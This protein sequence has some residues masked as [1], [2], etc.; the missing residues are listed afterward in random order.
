[1][2]FVGRT[3]ALRMAD[4]STEN[5]VKVWIDGEPQPKFRLDAPGGLYSLAEGLDSGEHTVEVVRLTECFLG[6]IQFQGFELDPS[7]EA[8]PWPE[9]ADRRI[10]FIGDSITCGY[11]V[12]ASDPNARFEAST[13]NFCDAY[14]GLTARQLKA[15][16]LVVARSGIG[17]VRNYNGPYE[18]SE[19]TMPKIYPE[20]FYQVEG[21]P[22]DFSRFV[23]QVVCINLGTND[24]STTG[25]NVETF[26]STY[27]DFARGVLERYP[28]ETQLVILQGPMNNDDALGGALARIVERLR[29]EAPERV[30]FLEL[31]AQG[32]LGFGASYH[33][34]RAQS[35]LNADELTAYLAELMDW[36]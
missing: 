34:N 26:V 10:E 18:G 7:G 28:D 4:A 21:A 5:Y 19:E 17:M 23:P 20:T 12:E 6:L 11:G 25:V 33:P 2:R 35:H 24:F 36:H 13:E 32:P 15:D 14:S 8:L 29:E 31:T 22:W 30:H 1:M 3:L 9:A 16:Y 27:I